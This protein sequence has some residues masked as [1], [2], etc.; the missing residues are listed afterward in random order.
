MTREEFM[1][2]YP[3]LEEVEYFHKEDFNKEVKFRNAWDLIID[4]W[5]KDYP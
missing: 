1:K 3:D 5:D 4:R 2:K